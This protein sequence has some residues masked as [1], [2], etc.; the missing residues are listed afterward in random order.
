M[1]GDETRVHKE[2][3]TGPTAWKVPSIEIRKGGGKT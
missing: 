2:T 1:T 3:F